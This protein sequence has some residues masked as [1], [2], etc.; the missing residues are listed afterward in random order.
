MVLDGLSDR[1]PY[2]VM[3]VGPGIV[4]VGAFILCMLATGVILAVSAY[5]GA[6]PETMVLCG[7]AIGS[8]C[9]AGTMILQYFADDIQLAAMV[10][11]SF[12]DLG[13][14]DWADLGL[15]VAV[16]LPAGLYFF[17]RRWDFNAVEAGDEMARGLGVHVSRLRLVGL[18]V[19]ALM[20]SVT[21]ACLGV[22]GFVGLVCPHGVRRIIGDD[23]RYLLPTSAVAGALLLLLA[24]TAARQ[25]VAPHVLPVSVLTS[26]LGAP[27]FL[28]LLV[29]KRR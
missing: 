18:M 10:F 8:L 3:S 24:D 9:T 21:V 29:R 28:W 2:A 12:G 13:R 11:W 25:I 20:V 16:L 7:V 23:H 17:L 19:S 1:L 5:R 14:A 15:M 4:A 6:S 22:I 27:T 26:F